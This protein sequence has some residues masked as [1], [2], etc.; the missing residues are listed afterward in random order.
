MYLIIIYMEQV[1]DTVNK[2][3][4]KWQFFQVILLSI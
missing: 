4:G 2:Q 3:I 1:L